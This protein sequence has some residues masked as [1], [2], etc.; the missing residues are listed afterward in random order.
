MEESIRSAVVGIH[1]RGVTSIDDLHRFLADWPIQQPVAL[2]VIR[3]KDQLTMNVRP[4]E[5]E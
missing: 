2:A 5:A 1:D 4:A 3:G